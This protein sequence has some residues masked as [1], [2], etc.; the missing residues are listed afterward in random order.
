LKPDYVEAFHNL[1]N[2]HRELE[3][4]EEATGSYERALEIDPDFALSHYQRALELMP[5]HTQAKYHLERALQQL[6]DLNLSPIAENPAVPGGLVAAT[7][8]RLNEL[9]WQMQLGSERRNSD[10]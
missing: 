4:L 9:R 5:E 3:R 1:G 2:S 10:T 8:N 6:P 7:W